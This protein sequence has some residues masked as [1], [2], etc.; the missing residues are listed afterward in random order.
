MRNIRKNN[1]SL[2]SGGYVAASVSVTE[3]QSANMCFPF[4]NQFNYK[5]MGIA[6]CFSF[7]AGAEMFKA[8]YL[9]Y[10]WKTISEAKNW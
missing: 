4:P 3:D 5:L 8:R 2:R 1:K 10:T 7:Y 9:F 6:F